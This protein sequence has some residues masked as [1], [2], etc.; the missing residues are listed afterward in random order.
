MNVLTS[1]PLLTTDDLLAMPDD[2]TERWLINGQLR[3]RP[4]SPV[5]GQMRERDMTVRNRFHSHLMARVTK[6][7]DNWRD[8]QPHPRGQALCGEVGVRLRRD[9]DTTV[10]VDVVYVAADVLARQT[11]ETTL[12]DG[13]PVLAVEILSPNDVLEEIHEK[14]DAYLQAGVALVWII[15][16]YDRTVRIYRPGEEPVLVNVRQELTAEP[17]LPGF[18][19][20]VV[21]LFE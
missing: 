16:P 17:H 21:R 19:V 15:D 5:N 8:D 6:F 3:E 7:L 20:P 2:G 10:G 9:P 13:V 11:N 14:I 4:P 12:V 18:R 1:P